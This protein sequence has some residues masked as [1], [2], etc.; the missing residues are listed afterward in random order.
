[1]KNAPDSSGDVMGTCL[2]LL[3]YVA[4]G[5]ITS[6]ILSHVS[7]ISI[8]MDNKNVMKAISGY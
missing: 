3:A 1:M 6:T 5:V 8:G 2:T 7:R 4:M